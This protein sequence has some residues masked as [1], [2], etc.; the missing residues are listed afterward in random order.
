MR[1]LSIVLLLSSISVSAL[2]IE[3]IE[4]PDQ[5]SVGSQKLVLNGAGLRSKRKFGMSFKVYVGALYLPAKNQDSK[6]IINGSDVKRLELVFLRSVDAATLREAW[7]E[8]FDKNCKPNCEAAKP[9]FKA[10]NELMVDVKEK[11]RLKLTFTGNDIQVE[12]EGKSNKSG[13]LT[14]EAIRQ[15]L[16]AIFIGDEPPT[17]DLKKALLGKS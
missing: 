11:S 13:Q 14:G 17:E 5:T 6:A 16:M 7:S 9:Q 10:F 1:F 15:A 12:V 2:S 4:F 8:G 3:K